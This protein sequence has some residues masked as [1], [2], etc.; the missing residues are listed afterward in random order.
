VQ[1]KMDPSNPSECQFV[2]YL[3]CLLEDG[4]AV[5]SVVLHKSAIISSLVL[6]D[7]SFQA[8]ANSIKVERLLK[9]GFNLRPPTTER[10]IWDVNVVLSMFSSWGDNSSLSIK[11]LLQK[12]LTLLAL[13]SACRISELA[14]LSSQIIQE[15]N[16]WRFHF[17]RWKKNSSR[18][19]QRLDLDLFFYSDVLLCPLRCLEAY[20]RVTANLRGNSEVLFI[21]LQKPFQPLRPN[22]LARHLKA[23]LHEAGIDTKRFSAHSFR[24]ASTSKAYSKGVPIES[25]LAQATWSNA[26]TFAKFYAKSIV[27]DQS[28]SN[29]VLQL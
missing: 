1:G 8:L 17:L 10:G 14:A 26:S 11:Q 2:N 15:D 25:I 6:R 19:K 12:S 23:I 4:L 9:G 5:N 3:A 20:L 24:S 7:Q 16:R 21:S 27:V 28:F 29:K 22:S 13:V 18:K